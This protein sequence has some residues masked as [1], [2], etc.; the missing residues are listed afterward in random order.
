MAGNLVELKVGTVNDSRYQ[1]YEC[2]VFTKL[3]EI[4]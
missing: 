1:R 2:G 4:R 3:S